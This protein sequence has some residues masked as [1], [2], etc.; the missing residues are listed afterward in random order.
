MGLRPQRRDGP[1]GDRGR[2]RPEQPRPGGQVGTWRRR[3]PCAR[4]SKAPRAIHQVSPG[5]RL[6]PHV[7]P[8]APVH[9]KPLKGRAERLRSRPACGARARCA[10]ADPAPPPQPRGGG[11]AWPGG[12]WSPPGADLRCRGHG[13]EEGKW[14]AASVAEQG[15]AEGPA[16]TRGGGDAATPHAG[17]VGPALRS[18]QGQCA[19][20]CAPSPSPASFPSLH[21]FLGGGGGEAGQAAPTGRAGVVLGFILLDQPTPPCA[22]IVPFPHSS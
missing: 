3:P 5:K 4:V 7:L 6:R 14:P 18:Q 17:L 22:V 20:R 19:G 13:D 12:L 16:G 9:E 10:L 1:R 8:E 2:E 15:A 11:G 21:R